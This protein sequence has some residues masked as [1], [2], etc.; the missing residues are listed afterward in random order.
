M[1][2]SFAGFVSWTIRQPDRDA[3]SELDL[4]TTI[5]QRVEILAG[6]HKGEIGFAQGWH[7]AVLR[8]RLAASTGT[9]I[10]VLPHDVRRAFVCADIVVLRDPQ[11]RRQFQVI[12]VDYDKAVLVLRAQCGRDATPHSDR[13]L[14]KAI[15]EV[16]F[17]NSVHDPDI[18][19]AQSLDKCFQPNKAI[20]VISGPFKGY[21]GKIHSLTR[22]AV[23]IDLEARAG[24]QD[25]HRE[26]LAEI[27]FVFLLFHS[28]CSKLFD[29]VTTESSTF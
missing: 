10:A 9:E 23:R 24:I 25:V 27:R 20:L 13:L 11:D 26:D 7:N 2:V 12:G 18:L 14:T 17:C 4:P 15:S 8:V 6:D 16:D 21:R 28:D 3:S 22:G 5:G 29:V 1:E 19:A